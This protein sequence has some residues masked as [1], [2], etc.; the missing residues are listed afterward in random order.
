[1]MLFSNRKDAGRQLGS[2]L[3]EEALVAGATDPLVI[4][5]PR[6]GVPV[7][8]AAAA[9][10]GT[11]FDIILVRKLGAPHQPELAL[12]AVAGG[13][14]AFVDRDLA[15]ALNV[16]PAVLEERK[17]EEQ[18]ELERQS[19]LYR[20]DRPAPRLAG[21][22]VI[23]VDDGIATGA[24]M[25]VALEALRQQGADPLIAAAPVGSTEAV[26]ELRNVADAVVCLAVAEA[27]RQVG[28]WDGQFRQVPGAEVV[29]TLKR[30]T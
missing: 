11:P 26:A 10:L 2:A 29:R 9:E 7:A 16:S 27:F 15:A 25:R 21:R 4:G 5:L 12:G 6:G 28:G 14:A 24:T 13:G 20:G 19:A 3:E 8:E 1:M 22:A 17:K 30:R 23:V 18:A